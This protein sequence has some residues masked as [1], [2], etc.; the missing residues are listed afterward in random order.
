MINTTFEAG[1]AITVLAG[2]AAA[3]PAQWQAS[4]KRAWSYGVYCVGYRMLSVQ[5]SCGDLAV[6]GVPFVLKTA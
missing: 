1:I 4:A 5:L 3:L 6:S 2:V